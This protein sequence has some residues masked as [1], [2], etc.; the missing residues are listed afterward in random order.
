MNSYIVFGKHSED[1]KRMIL[2][3]C[4]AI[5]PAQAII[6]ILRKCIRIGQNPHDVV[7]YVLQDDAK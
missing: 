4:K 2:G 3:E 7:A 6:K 5:G 1:T